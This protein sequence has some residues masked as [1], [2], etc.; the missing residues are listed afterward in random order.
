MMP[1]VRPLF[2]AHGGLKADVAAELG[3]TKGIPVTYKA[4][5]QPNNAL[6]LNVLEPGEEAA[7]AGTS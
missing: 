3:L 2:S 4:G 1:E 5:D 6:S 7:T